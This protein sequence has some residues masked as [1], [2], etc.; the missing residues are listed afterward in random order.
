[1]GL[2]LHESRKRLRSTSSFYPLAFD[3]MTPDTQSSYRPLEIR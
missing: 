2:G 3:E 1:M